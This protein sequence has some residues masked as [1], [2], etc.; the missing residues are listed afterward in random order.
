MTIMLEYNQ[1]TE[2]YWF[3]S[4]TGD[5]CTEARMS[6]LSTLGVDISAFDSCFSFPPSSYIKARDSV[7]GHVYTP[8]DDDNV[9]LQFQTCVEGCNFRVQGKR[10]S[11]I[12]NHFA[13]CLLRQQ[14][15]DPNYDTLAKLCG[16]LNRAI[17]TRLQQQRR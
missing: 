15:I 3:C 9:W 14:I 11:V 10:P 17:R 16:F 6:E 1:N 8:E 4:S 5:V 2:S 12:R 7:S 13:T